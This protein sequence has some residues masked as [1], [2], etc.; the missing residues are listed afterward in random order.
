MHPRLRQAVTAL[1]QKAGLRVS[2]E[3]WH[4]P[5][6]AAGLDLAIAW[7][8]ERLTRPFVVQIGAHDGVMHDGLRRHLQKRLWPALLIEPLP[9]AYNALIDVYR[10]APH[11]QTA[12]CAMDRENGTREL[13]RV[14]ADAPLPPDAQ[15]V[16]SFDRNHLVGI[17]DR[18]PGIAEWIEAIPVPTR[19]LETL[20]HERG[21]PEPDFLFVDAEG[22]DAIILNDVLDTGYRPAL[23]YVEWINLP[24]ISGQRLCVR[25]IELGYRILPT[26]GDLIAMRS[27]NIPEQVAT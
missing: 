5:E 3:R 19:R 9:D 17:R 10:G 6:N 8:S 2:R 15:L 11:I 27:L 7:L 24:P 16:A 4:P 14:K 13:F 1:T 26:G 12:N 20:L 21:L 18:V 23:I 22:H 25:L